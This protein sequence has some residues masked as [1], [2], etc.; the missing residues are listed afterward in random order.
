[1]NN[2]FLAFILAVIG[3]VFATRRVI[4]TWNAL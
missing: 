2:P 3:W 4:T 1:M